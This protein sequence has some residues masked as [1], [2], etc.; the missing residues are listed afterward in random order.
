MKSIYIFMMLFLCG[1]SACH[2]FSGMGNPDRGRTIF[3]QR[4]AMCHGEDGRGQNGMAPD[5]VGEWHRLTQSDQDLS[6]NIRAGGQRTPGKIYMSG[7]K[8]PQMLND[9]DMDDVLAFM[10]NA[11][12]GSQ[13]NFGR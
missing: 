12:G 7:L 9:R 5:L 6:R 13:L 10:R 4:C 11:F 3:L 2:A 1:I 8:P